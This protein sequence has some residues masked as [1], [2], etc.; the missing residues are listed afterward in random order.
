M[1]IFRRK[2]RPAHDPGVVYVLD[3]RA[4]YVPYY[5]VVC[6]C[7]WFAEPVE[8]ADYPDPRVGAEMATAALAHHQDA[9]TTVRFPLDRP[10]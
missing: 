9:E 5:S 2:P 1:A 3:R 6:R 8:V 4:D 7:G 10:E